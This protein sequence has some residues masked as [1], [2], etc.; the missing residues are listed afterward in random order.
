MARILVV[1]CLLE[2]GVLIRVKS[3]VTLAHRLDNYFDQSR[4]WFE[5]QQGKCRM[6]KLEG[7]E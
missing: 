6:P 1:H 3:D 4:A 7:A 5:P 2:K